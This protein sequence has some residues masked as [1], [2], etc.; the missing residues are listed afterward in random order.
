MP[1]RRRIPGAPCLCTSTHHNHEG[2]CANKVWGHNKA[3]HIYKLCDECRLW[4]KL[5]LKPNQAMSGPTEPLVPEQPRSLTPTTG[6]PRDPK[7]PPK[8]AKPLPAIS[9]PL[10]TDPIWTEPF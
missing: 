8:P 3:G 9:D 5:E 7:P 10:A 6:K 4:D 2:Y 1:P